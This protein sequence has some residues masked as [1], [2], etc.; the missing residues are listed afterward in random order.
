MDDE[1]W[2]NLFQHTMSLFI[3]PEVTRRLEAAQIDKSWRMQR[4]QVI[5]N[6]GMPVQIRLNEEVKAVF[7][8]RFTGTGAPTIGRAV[9]ADELGP[10]EGA[11]LTP[12]D[13]NAGHI[14]LLFHKDAWFITVDLRYNRARI[15]EYL[16]TVD[17]FLGAARDSLAKSRLR[18]F[19]DALFVSM[20]HLARCY[21]MFQPDETLLKRTSHGFVK[22]RFNR[23]FH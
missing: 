19:V 3:D 16:T 23:D 8:A 6:V 22:T 10:I 7:R 5:M 15:L 4:A 14:T 13:A 21:L 9:S 18:P 2:N 12:A 11:Q 17:Q 1:F 20:E